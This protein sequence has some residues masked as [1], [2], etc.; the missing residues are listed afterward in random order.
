MRYQSSLQ[1][2]SGKT[3]KIFYCLGCEAF[4]MTEID[5]AK[6]AGFLSRMMDIFYQNIYLHFPD[7]RNF[8]ILCRESSN[9]H[10]ILTFF[11]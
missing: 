10:K 2:K 5:D 6:E 11:V 7:Y 3:S 4:N 1:H 9:Y 8:C